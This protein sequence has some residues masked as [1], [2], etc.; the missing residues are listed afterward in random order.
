MELSTER[1]LTISNSQLT[2]FQIRR[3]S[4]KKGR[5]T[6][7]PLYETVHYVV[8]TFPHRDKETG[9][10]LAGVVVLKYHQCKHA[11]QLL[12]YRSRGKASTFSVR[13]RHA[14]GPACRG[15]DCRIAERVDR[16]VEPARI[17]V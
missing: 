6:P 3:N 12:F 16:I 15:N 14:D 10:S 9:S 17:K 13:A 1:S 7:W 8:A 5:S 4:N 11:T 2:L